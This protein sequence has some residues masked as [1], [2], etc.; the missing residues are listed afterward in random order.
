LSKQIEGFA[1]P[2]VQRLGR[3]QVTVNSDSQITAVV[4]NGAASGKIEVT[5]KGGTVASPKKFA[6]N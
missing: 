4:P 5:T 6:V 2:P 1:K 3:G